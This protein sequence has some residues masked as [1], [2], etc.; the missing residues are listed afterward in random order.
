MS[1]K[2]KILQQ[3]AENPVI[4]YMKG[5]PSAPECGFSAK[6]VAI[7][8][9]TKIPYAYVNVLQ[10]PFIREKLPSISKWPTY[11]QVFINGELI[12]GADIVEAMHNDGSLLPKLQ[13]AVKPAADAAASQTIT[14][15]EVEALILAEYPGA[16]IAIEGQGCDLNITVVSDLFAEQPMIKQHQGVMA[17]L[18]EPL[19]SGRLHAVTLKTHTAAAWAALQPAAN[20]GLLQIQI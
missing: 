15:S 19:A 5:V 1:V 9:Q 13:A 18:S 14:H 10:A 6:T 17:T 8:N 7:L 2:E 20:P 4:I 11:P 16:K 12:G 3:L